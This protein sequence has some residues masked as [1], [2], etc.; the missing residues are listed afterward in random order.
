[1]SIEHNL[2]YCHPVYS[3]LQSCNPAS[4]TDQGRI[5]L[6]GPK[7]KSLATD[8]TN[9]SELL[10]KGFAGHNKNQCSSKKCIAAIVPLCYVLSCVDLAV[11]DR[12]LSH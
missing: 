9:A 10:D 12:F 11:T 8:K 2:H 7:F 6:V 1:M 5:C 4:N 3:F